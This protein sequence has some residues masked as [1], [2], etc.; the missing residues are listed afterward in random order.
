MR[1]SRQHERVPFL[2]IIYQYISFDVENL[3]LYCG[4]RLRQVLKVIR[5]R[6]DFGSKL[7]SLAAF[8]KGQ[9]VSEIQGHS[10]ADKK[11]STLQVCGDSYDLISEFFNTSRGTKDWCRPSHRAQ[12]GTHVHGIYCPT[13]E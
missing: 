4:N 5:G 6:E 11:W 8:K 2:K 3:H 7:V 12:L 10:S 9:I 13:L 1:L